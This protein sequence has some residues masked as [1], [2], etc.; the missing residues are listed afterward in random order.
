V[1]SKVEVNRRDCPLGSGGFRGIFRKILDELMGV[2]GVLV[3]LSGKF[4][5]GE[6]VSF[7]MGC[8]S[9]GV[10]MRCKVV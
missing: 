6:M 8:G 2:D 7:P 1:I 3:R 9:G 10:S 5:R 4:V